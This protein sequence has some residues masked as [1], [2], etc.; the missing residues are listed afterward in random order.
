MENKEIAKTI[1]K[2]IAIQ[3]RMA[4]TAWGASQFLV[5]KNG[6]QFR[7]RTPKYKIGVLV[8]IQLNSMDTYDIEVFRLSGAY[9]KVLETAKDIY[10]D[11]MIETLDELIEG[12][13]KEVILF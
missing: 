11:M 3:D 2:Q 8:K 4:L 13:Q 10:V 5:I 6:V 12:K 9:I 7:I 1:L